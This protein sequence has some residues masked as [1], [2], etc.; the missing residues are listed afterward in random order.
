MP[1]LR[2][3]AP[4]RSRAPPACLRLEEVGRAFPSVPVRTSSGDRVLATVPSTPALVVATPGAEPVAEGGYSCVVLLDTWLMLSRTDLRTAEE[5]VRRWMNAAALACPASA[6]GRVVAVGES[7][8]PALQALVRWDPGGFAR[9]EMGER[10]SAH[11]PPGSRLATITGR[12]DAVVAVLDAL[13]LPDGGEI[14]GPVPVEERPGVRPPDEPPE[15]RAVV[16]VPRA[17]GKELS[18]ALV[19]VQ[20]VRAAKKLEPVRVQVDPVTLG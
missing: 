2:R 14:L 5:A 18:R 19:A 17:H 3:A 15:V 4:G 11:L 16:R 8:D 9:R 20:G 13:E 7:S 12:D 1:H 6:G 10:Q